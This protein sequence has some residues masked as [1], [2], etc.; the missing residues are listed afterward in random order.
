MKT[1]IVKFIILCLLLWGIPIVADA[2]TT[3]VD[4]W[5]V[6]VKTTT[7]TSTLSGAGD[8]VQE[9]FESIDEMPLGTPTADEVYD[10]GDTIDYSSG[11]GPFHGTFPSGGTPEIWNTVLR[12][13][14]WWLESRDKSASDLNFLLYQKTSGVAAGV[15]YHAIMAYSR[16]YGSTIT[17]DSAFTVGGPAT[18]FTGLISNDTGVV[19]SD[20]RAETNT[21]AN[22]LLVDS[23]NDYVYCEA[24]TRIGDV[25][26]AGVFSVSKGDTTYPIVID[27]ASGEIRNGAD[28]GA[29][30]IQTA[31]EMY[32]AGNITSG[33]IVSGASVSGTASIST[34]G[35]AILGDATHRGR[36][37]Y[38]DGAGKYVMFEADALVDNVTIDWSAMH[39]FTT[40][41]LFSLVNAGFDHWD[42]T[43]VDPATITPDTN[44]D[45]EVY[46][47]GIPGAGTTVT[48]TLTPLG[49]VIGVGRAGTAN[50]GTA[51]IA[52]WTPD[53][54]NI[55]TITFTLYVGV[56][57]TDTW[58]SASGSAGL[59]F[60][61]VGAEQISEALAQNAYIQI[62]ARVTTQVGTLDVIKVT[63]WSVH[64]LIL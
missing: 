30:S 35:D 53:G 3:L 48:A 40:G 22:A 54:G 5:R 18:F 41:D 60:S 56:N 57:A 62:Q 29:Y 20:F 21:Y 12:T 27:G 59:S 31:T 25:N 8:D 38:Y 32:A 4:A 28:Q 63:S 19:G 44:T 14:N 9:I 50:H 64:E 2:A 45:G 11:N 17:I 23:T 26:T 52:T 47:A 15:Q 37:L 24:P 36:T 55:D 46:S 39:S 6:R 33:G 10:E 7:L 13:T 49:W 42:V 43:P 61:N 58:T 16:D 1:T 51:Y 34:L